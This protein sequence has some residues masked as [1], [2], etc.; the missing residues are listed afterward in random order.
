MRRPGDYI[1]KMIALSGGRYVFSDAGLEDDSARSTLNMQMEAFCAGAKD[2]DILIYNATVGGGM[3]TT[4][5]LLRKGPWL[6]E[7]QA[8]KSGSVWCTELNLFQQTSGIAEMIAEL[9]AIIS[10]SADA[11]ALQYFH[12]LR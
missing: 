12:R 2:A 8:V 4:E 6:S 3:D 5:E 9:H 7:F 11:D 1:P 10:G